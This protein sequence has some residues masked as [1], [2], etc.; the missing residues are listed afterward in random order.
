MSSNTVQDTLKE[1]ANTTPEEITKK[2]VKKSWFRWW[3]ANEI[4][5]SVDRYLAGSLLWAMMPIL[6][7]LYKDEDELKRVYQ[8]YLVYYNTNA[9]WGGGL[10]IGILS[11]MEEKRAKQLH[12]TGDSM[13]SDSIIDTTKE[14]LMG[15][16]AGIGD[17]VDTFTVMYTLIAIGL[18]WALNGNILG[19]LLPWVVFAL[20]QFIIGSTFTQMGNAIGTK[21][22]S[23]VVS[24]ARSKVIIDG[25]RIIGIFMMGILVA[26]YVDIS[27]P[28]TWGSGQDQQSI[29][30]MLDSVL[31]GLI[32]LSVTLGIYYYFT[33]KE[34]NVMKVA[35]IVSIVLGVLAAIGIL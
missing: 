9:T 4:P 19:A 31:P 26:N 22:A 2:D 34:F 16:L 17:S 12:E 20:Y 6:K 29:Q 30:A 14:G 18:P 1:E 23:K 11:D 3:F 21:A 10:V 32:P 27:T 8:R 28:L 25:L 33:K 13:I 24:G 7:K 35:L 15:S 5:H